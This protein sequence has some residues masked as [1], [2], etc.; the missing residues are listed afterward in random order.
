VLFVSIRVERF[1][2]DTSE[3]VL[4]TKAAN[5]NYPVNLI[6]TIAI[7]M[8]VLVHASFFP[9]SIPGAITPLVMVNWFTSDVFGAIG[10]LGVPLF[11]MLSG[12]LLL[13]PPKADES[14]GLFYRKRFWRVGLPLIFWTAIYFVW[15]FY[16]RG[17]PASLFSIGQG[18]ISGSYPILWF[19][20]L[21]VGLYLVTPMLR[22]LVKHIDRKQFTFLLILWFVGTVSV[23]LIHTFTD[24]TFDPLMF[25]VTDWVGFF[26][27]GIYLVNVKIRR[28]LAYLGLISGLSVAVLGAW[29]LTALQGE[30]NVD[31]FHGY[32]SFNM[33][34]ASAALFLILINVPQL[35]ISSGGNTVFNRLI[36]WIGQNTLPIYLLHVIVLETLELA[37]LGFLWPYTNNLLIDTPLLAFVTFAITCAIIYPL[38]KIPYIS[39]LIG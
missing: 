23:P 22:T 8:V 6:R 31:Y 19:L 16:V 28:A 17:N 4:Q 37:Y 20:Y 13:N 3:E 33:I 24:F 12:A 14:M 35:K 32:L 38:K 36:S 9:Y 18:L 11:V 25:V 21:I 2:L 5:V 30:Q 7:G 34:I 26:L 1:N 39:K 15:S 29:L 27:L 10:Y